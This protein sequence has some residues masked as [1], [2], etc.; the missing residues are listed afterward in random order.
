MADVL[1]LY[2]STHGHTAKIAARIA[3]GLRAGGVGRV[4]V[5]DAADAGAIDPAAFDGVI[6]GGSL[7]AGRHQ[8]E[9]VEWVKAHLAVLGDRPSAFFS[10]SLTA[11]DE[12][13]E[14]RE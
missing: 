2:A 7:H 4:D 6:V 5:R 9:P 12:T 14:A 3:E 10:V 1:L 13:S 8:A 11:A